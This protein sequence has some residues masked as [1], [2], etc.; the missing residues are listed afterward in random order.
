MKKHLPRWVKASV[1]QHF[2][3]RITPTIVI[4]GDKT[5][6]ADTWCE[7]RLEGP[8]Y[9]ERSGMLRVDLFVSILI[10]YTHGGTKLYTLE[11]LSGDIANAFTSSIS[12]YRYGDETVDTGTFVDCLYLKPNTKSDIIIYPIGRVAPDLDVFQSKVE[13]LYYNDDFA[14]H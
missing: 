2:A 10:Q 14:G 1:A 9:T 12:I 8:H 3:T 13:G 5:T 7:L 6:K 4:D 11:T